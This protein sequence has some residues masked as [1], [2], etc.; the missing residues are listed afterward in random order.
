MGAG[1]LYFT[2]ITEAVG[3]SLPPL[4]TGL[5]LKAT[6]KTKRDPAA[7]DGAKAAA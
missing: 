6:R 2:W 3:V 5:L 7:Q 4:A 1:W